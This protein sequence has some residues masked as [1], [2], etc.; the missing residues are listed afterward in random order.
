MWLL[1]ISVDSGLCRFSGCGNPMASLI[2]G[3]S[4]IESRYLRLLEI[5]P[6]DPADLPGFGASAAN[7]SSFTGMADVLKLSSS[8]SSVS[9]DMETSE[10]E[11]SLSTVELPTMPVAA[12]LSPG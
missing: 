12:G 9:A 8:S 2:L 6:F 5:I 4:D 1:G 7:T 3:V 11:S 10:A